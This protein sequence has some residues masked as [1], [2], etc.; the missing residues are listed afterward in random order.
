MTAAAAV[1]PVRPQP[2]GMLIFNPLLGPQGA[3][4]LFPFP[5]VA[6]WALGQRLFPCCPRPDRRCVETY[7]RV[8]APRLKYTQKPSRIR[9]PCVF[10]LQAGEAP[11]EAEGLRCGV[12]RSNGVGR[13]LP[14]PS[15]PA[16]LPLS[17]SPHRCRAP[18]SSPQLWQSLRPRSPPLITGAVRSDPSGTDRGEA[19][20]IGRLGGSRRE[21]A[22]SVRH[23]KFRAVGPQ[24]CTSCLASLLEVMASEGRRY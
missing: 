7:G 1:G 11:G 20:R 17:G 2:G 18:S 15:R 9:A 21:S 10:A 4:S 24:W 3:S 23:A 13:R 12:S 5:H 6:F 14:L 22:A 8:L 19:A 16:E